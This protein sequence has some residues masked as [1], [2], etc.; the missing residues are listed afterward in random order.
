MPL[1]E[2]ILGVSLVSLCVIVIGRV[3]KVTYKKASKTATY[4]SLY[5]LNELHISSN[6]IMFKYLSAFLHESRQHLSGNIIIQCKWMAPQQ[7]PIIY[8]IKY[9]D[10]IEK[11]LTNYGYIWVK[12]NVLPEKNINSKVIGFDIMWEKN[13]SKITLQTIGSVLQKISKKNE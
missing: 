9:T 1:L 13:N 11:I 2:T 8:N 4:A 12:I 7:R 10:G 3:G 6:D 5:D